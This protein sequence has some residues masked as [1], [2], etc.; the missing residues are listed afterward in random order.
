M[1]QQINIYIMHEY[2]YNI[3]TQAAT[4]ENNTIH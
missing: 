2:W 3:T 1:L 4:I